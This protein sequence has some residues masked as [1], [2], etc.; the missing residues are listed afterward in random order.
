MTRP[1]KFL[2]GPSGWIVDQTSCVFFFYASALGIPAM[3]LVIY[4]MNRRQ[5]MAIA[6]RQ[7]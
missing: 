3:L 7:T 1:A 6:A 4:L 5:Q 2:G